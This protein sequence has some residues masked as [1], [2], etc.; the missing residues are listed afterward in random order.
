MVATLSA[1]D[2]EAAVMRLQRVVIAG[3][4]EQYG[5]GWRYRAAIG[6]N[7]ETGA[8]RW[9]SKGGFTTKRAAK[10]ALTAVL[11]DADKGVVVDRSPL[12]VGEYL[13]QWLDGVAGDLKPT[14]LESYRQAVK[15]LERTM[16]DVKLQE[17]RPLTVERAYQ[18]LTSSGLAAKT[19]RC[20]AR[21]G[22]DRTA[23]SCCLP[24][25]WFTAVPRARAGFA[26]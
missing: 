14:T 24:L 18:K 17:L 8:R 4:V 26:V 21:Q 11:A 1:T 25:R 2:W 19:V 6:T 9:V 13:D 15:R 10:A 22:V 3:T 7:P 12:T 23:N 5:K 20:V 16:G